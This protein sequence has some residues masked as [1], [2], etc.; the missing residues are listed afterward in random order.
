ME[1]NDLPAEYKKGIIA[2]IKE[3]FNKLFSNKKDVINK[4]SNSDE[5]KIDEV[6]ILRESLRESLR[7]KI[8]ANMD[9]ISNLSN[10]RLIEEYRKNPDILDSLTVEKL[11]EISAYYD[12]LI[13][14]CNEELNNVS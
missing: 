11:K 10:D 9:S 5:S 12:E 13:E 8:N 6:S 1:K 2:K 4:E 3:I 14:K 7:E